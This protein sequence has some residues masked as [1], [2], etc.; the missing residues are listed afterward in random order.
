MNKL[1]TLSAYIVLVIHF[2]SSF[3]AERDISAHHFIE[4]DNCIVESDCY[5]DIRGQNN[6]ITTGK[7]IIDYTK[8]SAINEFDGEGNRKFV[9]VYYSDGQSII[10]RLSKDDLLAKMKDKGSKDEFISIKNMRDRGDMLVNV[11]HITYI[12]DRETDLGKFSDVGVLGNGY[13]QDTNSPRLHVLYG[14]DTNLVIP[15][16]LS[17]EHIFQLMKD[18]GIDS[19][20]F[21]ESSS[22][23][24]KVFVKEKNIRIIVNI[25]EDGCGVYTGSGTVSMTKEACSHASSKMNFIRVNRDE[26]QGDALI[27]VNYISS[28]NDS[29]PYNGTM[30]GIKTPSYTNLARGVLST[31]SLQDIMNGIK[32]ISPSIHDD[33][34]ELWAESFNGVIKEGSTSWIRAKMLSR[35]EYSTY[36]QENG[37]A[38]D[39]DTKDCGA[40]YI[41]IA[42]FDMYFEFNVNSKSL[43]E[44]ISKIESKGEKI[45]EL[46]SSR[47]GVMSTKR[48][49]LSTN[50]FTSIKDFKSPGYNPNTDI[51]FWKYFSNPYSGYKYC[52]VNES[53]QEIMDMIINI[54]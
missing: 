41:V 11:R 13:R 51:H 45:I 54:D 42:P 46:T 4:I 31:N 7:T 48:I 36:R 1:L 28:V 22:V 30:I 14:H 23:K 40:F 39:E 50:D 20:D 35:I 43:D 2:S 8:I 26:N 10:L 38:L 52:L 34:V 16:K 44:L 5:G 19:N 9:S 24:G 27:N 6:F 18:R 12:R 53:A 47:A 17:A 21:L 25:Y 33:F 37:C 15:V 32:E 49:L 3:G 29:S